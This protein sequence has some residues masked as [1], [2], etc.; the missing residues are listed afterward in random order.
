[1]FVTR[2]VPIALHPPDVR[3]PMRMGVGFFRRHGLYPPAEL[4]DLATPVVAAGTPVGWG[5]GVYV[6]GRGGVSVIWLPLARRAWDGFGFERGVGEG[7]SSFQ[8]RSRRRVGTSR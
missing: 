5:E 2:W 7:V 6:A 3:P 4:V 8:K 1:V